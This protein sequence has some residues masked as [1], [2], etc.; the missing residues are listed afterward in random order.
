VRKGALGNPRYSAYPAIRDQLAG[1][2]G[3]EC[4]RCETPIASPFFDFNQSLAPVNDGRDFF[5]GRSTLISAVSTPR[6]L[7]CK[8]NMFWA[9]ANHSAKAVVVISQESRKRWPGL[10]FRHR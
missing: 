4:N 7:D 1:D 8:S 6:L 10:L 3:W 5:A 2:S 9:G